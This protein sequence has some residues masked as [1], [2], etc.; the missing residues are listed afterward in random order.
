MHNLPETPF[1]H[2]CVRDLA[3]VI[4]S[5]PLVSGEIE[6]VHWWCYEDGLREYQDCLPRLYQLD[7]NPQ[8]LVK[9]LDNLKTKRLGLR[10]EA[11]LA[12]WLEIS[13]NYEVILQNKQLITTEKTLGEIDFI[14]KDLRSAHLIHLEVAV[15]FYLGTD[16]LN[17]P[18]RWFGTTVT[19]QLGKKVAHLRQHQTQLSSKYPEHFP[20]VVDEC[21]CILKGRL[22]YPEGKNT[23]PEGI[24]N[25]HLTGRWLRNQSTSSNTQI[26]VIPI[27]KKDWLATL[28][29]EQLH[30]HTILSHYPSIDMPQCYLHLDKHKE[31][32][33]RV[34]ILPESFK[35][36]NE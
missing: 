7:K 23:M 33:E 24:A 15:K 5:P 14:I 19:D 18:Y 20:Y 3:W 34:F 13:P 9:H 28:S 21:Q 31:K 6:G 22:F 4:A 35:F 25:N 32:L 16:D 8:A 27:D 1:K 10:F 12:F 30:E 29:Q 11:L 2:Q 17:D 26:K 36:P